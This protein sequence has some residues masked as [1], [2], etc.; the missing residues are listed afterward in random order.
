M[1]TQ[2]TTF[3]S[4][5]RAPK[6]SKKWNITGMSDADMGSYII[7]DD[8]YQTFLKLHHDHVFV[9][10]KP[11]S[12]LERRDKYGPILVDLD[13]RYNDTNTNRVIEIPQIISFVRT[14]STAFYKF[15]AYINPIRFFIELKPTP[16][17]E[18]DKKTHKY[19]KK[20]GVHIICPDV[21]ISY[22]SQQALRLYLL[23]NNI[24]SEFISYTN[25]PDDVY[26]EHV[27][28]SNNWF[29]HGAT[30][31]DKEQY[32]IQACVEVTPTGDVRSIE[33]GKSDLELTQNF[34]L[35]IGRSVPTD[36][37]VRPSVGDEWEKW[38]QKTKKE[39]KEKKDKTLSTVTQHITNVLVDD[40]SETVRT[41]VSESISKILRSPGFNWEVCECDDGYQLKH[42]S[43]NCIVSPDYKHSDLNHSC[44]Y[45]HP[46]R[47]ILSCLRH[48]SKKLSKEAAASLWRL[49]TSGQ[50]DII[51]DDVYA[52]KRFVELMGDE[53]H[54]EG[55]TVYIF[56]PKTGMW[57]TTETSLLAA[58][59]RFKDELVF[60]KTMPN[61]TEAV[62]NYGGCTKN[63]KNMLVHLRPLLTDGNFIS[64]N[65]DVSLPF[66]LFE[67]GI[68]HIPTKTF[69]RGF[70]KT[71]VF[72]ARIPRKFPEE[73]DPEVESLVNEKLFVLPLQ[74]E[75]VGLY[76]KSRLARSI[77]GCYRDKKF[78][79]VLGE[80]D[81]SK[82]TLTHALTRSFG[83]YVVEYNANH[84]KYN[85]R[86]GADEAKRLSWLFPIKSSRLAISNEM[87]MDK[88][89][90]DGNLLKSVSSGGDEIGARQN[91]KDESS[92]ILRTSFFFMGNDMPEITPKDTGI[93][94]RVRVVRFNKRF[95]TS[96]TL[97]NELIADPTIKDKLNT[98]SWKNAVFWLIMDAYNTEIGTEPSE[99]CEETREWI[100]SGSTEFKNI[101]EENFIINIADTD[102]N[103]FVTS[104]EIIEFVKGRGLNMS[105]TKIGR[106]LVKIGLIKLDK[107]IEGKTIRIWKG[108][109]NS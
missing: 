36:L 90:I 43:Y 16:V 26:D 47:T 64:S 23:N 19:I 104:R 59:H 84:L 91:F 61:G 107:K 5:H 1:A 92:F 69:T 53:I 57:N 103:N 93:E 7:N 106:E 30:K 76:L 52:C 9:Y 18:V 46:G 79:C 3:M 63:V 71:K 14:F 70:D 80:A 89:P 22:E 34:S 65:I 41:N 17:I 32:K 60:R 50:E 29:L 78:V 56:D 73:R 2:L 54:R 45:V 94:T 68:F 72:M 38:M 81:C 25:S 12:Y 40:D 101:L 15:F 8:E 83:E 49:L 97:P 35:K 55:D 20:D 82:G 66:L 102:C 33:H 10:N 109:H 11:S 100:P 99:V 4:T 87:R 85:P 108:I 39:K 95:V 86:T 96:P 31:Q 74:N 21:T 28:K 48:E 105:D 42:N 24:L 77:A 51:I 88:I 13:F 67:D 98:D 6:G 44:V 75:G 62:Y 58:V 37:P 27:I